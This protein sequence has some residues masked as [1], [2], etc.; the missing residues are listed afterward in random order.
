MSGILRNIQILSGNAIIRT[1]NNNK[2][3]VK[4]QLKYSDHSPF[5]YQ[6]G[7]VRILEDYNEEL[8]TYTLDTNN[9]LPLNKT[10]FLCNKMTDN[11]N[12]N[13]YIKN[14]SNVKYYYFKIFSKEYILI[15]AV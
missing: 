3:I 11:N 6:Y 12:I 10:S 4:K 1:S 5:A 14:N 9:Q 13:Y 7:H 2:Y 8:N 15:R